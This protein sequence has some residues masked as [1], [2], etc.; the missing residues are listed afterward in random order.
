MLQNIR[1]DAMNS[2]I[3]LTQ[4]S[5]SYADYTQHVNDI[6]LR[7]RQP[8]M[9]DDFKRVRFIKGLANSQLM[10]KAKSHCSPKKGISCRSWSYKII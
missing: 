2:P 8:L 1:D 7:P 4:G 9:A 10:T 5:L 6:L 3:G